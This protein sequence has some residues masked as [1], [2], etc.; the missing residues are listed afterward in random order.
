MKSKNELRYIE[1]PKKRKVNTVKKKRAVI[2]K[3]IELS[4]LCGLD[5]FMVVFDR[6]NQKIVEFNSDQ[7]FDQHV[8]SHIL[9]KYNKQQFKYSP[10]ITNDDYDEFVG[11]EKKDASGGDNLISDS[12]SEKESKQM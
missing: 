8:I 12:D 9:D 5:I 10:V 7:D 1:D 2:K 3:V 11:Y 6:N 4:A